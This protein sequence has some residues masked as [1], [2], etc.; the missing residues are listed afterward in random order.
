MAKVMPKVKTC[1]FCGGEAWVYRLNS[2]FWVVECRGKCTFI[3]QD[4]TEKQAIKHWN[5]R[6]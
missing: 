1:P 4:L 3:F 5:I 6:V 2:D